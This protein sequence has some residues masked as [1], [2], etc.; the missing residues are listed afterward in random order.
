ML[1]PAG[2]VTEAGTVAAL[3]FEVFRATAVPE[4]PA[5]PESVTVPVEVLPPC[6]EAGAS[7][8]DASE[9]GL[10]VRPWVKDALP[11]I[12]VI[13]A[14]VWVSTPFVDAANDADVLPEATVTVA[15]TVAE[16]LSLLSVTTDPAGPAGPES[17][18]VP[19][20]AEPPPTAAGD[21]DR[22]ARLAGTTVRVAV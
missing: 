7:V 9:A 13:F 14:V 19:V 5:I 10:I 1:F 17:V 16:A 11:R 21:R 8:S 22:P 12:A 20:D 3:A 18:T 4:G 6:T 15:G 2:T